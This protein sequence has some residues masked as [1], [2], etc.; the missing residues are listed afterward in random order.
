M[1]TVLARFGRIGVLVNNAGVVEPIARLAE[2]DP[3]AWGQSL[4]RAEFSG[5]SRLVARSTAS[6]VS[7]VIGL[8]RA[9]GGH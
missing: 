1:A 4:E 5:A 3:A 9:S 2:A 8:L 7:A 6:Q